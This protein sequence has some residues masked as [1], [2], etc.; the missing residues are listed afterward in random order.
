MSTQKL[1]TRKVGEHL[2]ALDKFILAT[3]ESGYKGTSSAVAEIVDNS[4][5]ARA[6]K[7][8][9]TIESDQELGQ[10]EL[11]VTVLDDGCGMSSSTLQEALRFGGT[12]R[13]NDR[14]GLGRYGMGLPNSSLSQA[15]RLEVITWQSPKQANACRL[16][17]VIRS[18]RGKSSLAPEIR[19]CIQASSCR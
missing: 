11:K 13:F 17:S 4:I 8:I 10:Q 6:S 16:Y 12:T 3:R 2:V 14:Q 7:V 18:D 15:R 9:V 1:T 19:N 5:Q